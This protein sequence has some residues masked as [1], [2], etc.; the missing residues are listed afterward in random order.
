MNHQYIDGDEAW[1]DGYYPN[2]LLG[3]QGFEEFIRLYNEDCNEAGHE[4]DVVINNPEVQKLIK[5]D[6]LKVLS[7][8]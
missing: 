7:W 2:I 5:E 6:G 3:K 4:K 1:G 8:G